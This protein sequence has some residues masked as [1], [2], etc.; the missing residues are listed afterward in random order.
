MSARLGKNWSSNG[1][2]L[3]P[4]LHMLRNLWP[5]RGPT[6]G[7]AINYLDGSQGGQSYW[8]QDGGIPNLLNKYFQAVLNRVQ[9]SPGDHGLDDLLK[10]NL[11]LRHL[12][13]FTE[14]LDVFKPI[15][16]WFA[17]GVD[18][19]NG[20]LS[21]NGGMLDLQWDISASLPL[22]EEIAR[23]H[24]ELAEATV[25]IP[26][27]LPGWVLE[28]DLIT[29]HALGGC[30][31]GNSLADGVVNHAGEVFGYPGLYV[32]DGA[33]VPHALGV[34]PSRTIGALAERISSLMTV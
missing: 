27:P 14:T 12:T 4:A 3:T 8:V 34:N 28:K 15:M 10:P 6:I 17:L 23:K 30:N 16:P 20:D 18:A 22:F 24:Q 32:A 1:D 19:G 33:I 7:S 29:P 25:G 5:D 2:F 9:E 13:L 26:L 21:F 31:M 11:L